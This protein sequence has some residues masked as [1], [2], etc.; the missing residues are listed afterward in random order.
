MPVTKN[1]A[2][3]LLRRLDAAGYKQGY[4]TKT[5][6]PDWWKA[7]LVKD[8]AAFMETVSHVANG[9]GL[10]AGSLLDPAAEI[11]REACVS[12]KFKASRSVENGQLE[13]AVGIAERLAKAAASACTIPVSPLPGSCE[14]IR[15]AILSAH[16]CIRFDN[17]LEYCWELGIIVLPV[18]RFPGRKPDGM[19][20]M[21]DDRPLIILCKSAPHPAW[22]VFDLAHEL[23]HIIL[24]HVGEDGVV[25]DE[26]IDAKDTDEEE[27]GANEFAVALL[28][29]SP[30]TAFSSKYRLAAEVLASKAKVLGR[31]HCIDPGVI[32]LN[33]ART[34]EQQGLACWGVANLALKQISVPYAPRELLREN[35]LAKLDLEELGRDTRNWLLR[36]TES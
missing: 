20:L 26:K 2:T 29:G 7:S 21:V 1:K 3:A 24:G 13:Q 6:L 22:T 5:V 32:V 9:L 10:D 19:A 8:D 15:N 12:A 35:L 16:D 33:Y 28:A 18:A 25:V 27:K 23:G 34:M 14:D 31:K 36:A 4:V 30:Q 17:L 11:R